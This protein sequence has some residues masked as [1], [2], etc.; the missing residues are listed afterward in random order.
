LRKAVITRKIVSIPEKT[1][2]K[3]TRLYIKL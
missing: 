2:S 3:T 1:R